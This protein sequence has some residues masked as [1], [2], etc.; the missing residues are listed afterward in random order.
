[1]NK[2]FEAVNCPKCGSSQC[3]AEHKVT[4][5]IPGEEPFEDT[6]FCCRGAC[7]T[8]HNKG[9]AVAYRVNAKRFW[10]SEV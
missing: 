9:K 4:R 7:K 5:Q 8:E 1:M 3:F 2:E 6:L 10:G